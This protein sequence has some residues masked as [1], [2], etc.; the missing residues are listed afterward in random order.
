MRSPEV[1]HLEEQSVQDLIATFEYE[2]DLAFSVA[3]TKM[4]KEELDEFR[5]HGVYEQVLCG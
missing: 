4:R 1:R 2:L 3:E 5:K